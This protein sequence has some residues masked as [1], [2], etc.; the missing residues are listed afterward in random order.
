MLEK[1]VCNRIEGSKLDRIEGPKLALIIKI[2]LMGFL[3][4]HKKCYYIIEFSYQFTKKIPKN[5]F[6]RI[7][8]ISTDFYC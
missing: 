2:L 8:L 3:Y 6:G 5:G 4:L 1:I 7:Q